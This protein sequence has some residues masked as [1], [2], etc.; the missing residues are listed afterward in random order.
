[1][2]SLQPGRLYPSGGKIEAEEIGITVSVV[3]M[4]AEGNLQLFRG[5]TERGSGRSMSL[6]RKPRPASFLKR[7]RK[8][9]GNF[10][11]RMGRA[12]NRVEKGGQSP[13]QAQS[14]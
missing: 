12:W 6:S 9:F 14:L 13:W 7:K 1:M 3:V 5:W 4:D 11:T 10:A 8:R 2:I